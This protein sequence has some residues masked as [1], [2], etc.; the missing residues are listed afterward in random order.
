MRLVEVAGKTS[1][2]GCGLGRCS[3]GASTA[4]SRAPAIACR[5]VEGLAAAAGKL[6][7]RARRPAAAGA[8]VRLL[9]AEG[10]AAASCIVLL[11]R[12]AV[13]KA[14]V[15]RGRVRGVIN[16]RLDQHVSASSSACGA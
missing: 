1:T 3:L 12:Q 9:Q 14:T 5:D 13:I 16:G 6:A 7:A 4:A 15:R 2:A 11:L 10:D 8:A